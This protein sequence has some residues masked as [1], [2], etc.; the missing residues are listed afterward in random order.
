VSRADR[1][2][3]GVS[4]AT[5]RIGPTSEA[6]I[7]IPANFAHEAREDAHTALDEGNNAQFLRY[8]FAREA[9][10]IFYEDGSHP[11]RL[12]PIQQREET[13]ARFDGISPGRRTPQ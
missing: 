11:I 2:I 8:K 13:R 9:R 4:D 10:C 6:V 1:S 3:G 12:D 5:S 7:T